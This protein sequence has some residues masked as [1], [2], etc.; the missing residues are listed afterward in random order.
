MLSQTYA[1]KKKFSLPHITVFHANFVGEKLVNTS[2]SM[3]KAAQLD[4]LYYGSRGHLEDKQQCHGPGTPGVQHCS[5][6]AQL[7]QHNCSSQ[8]GSAAPA[9]TLKQLLHHCATACLACL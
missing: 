1:V 8:M 9:S 2:S 7:Q 4:F 3:L 6:P 5:S